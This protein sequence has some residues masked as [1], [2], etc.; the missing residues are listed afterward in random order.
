MRPS[1]PLVWVGTL[2]KA[3]VTTSARVGSSGW[4][5]SSHTS[6]DLVAGRL[7]EAH[8]FGERGAKRRERLPRHVDLG[9][10]SFLGLLRAHRLGAIEALQE[11]LDAHV[12]EVIGGERVAGCAE[13]GRV[14]P[15]RDR[16]GSWW[17]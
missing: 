7:D 5:T 4:L 9:D 2:K 3:S 17:G 12:V 13:L 15:R 6:P 8:V 1:G 11:G 16:A 10:E 14:L